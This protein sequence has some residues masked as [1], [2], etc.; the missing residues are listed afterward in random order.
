LST[1]GR[2]C[3]LLNI[4]S[5]N[6]TEQAIEQLLKMPPTILRSPPSVADYVSLSEYQAQTP[7]T[8]HGG[9]PVLYYHATSVI[10][11]VFKSQCSSL[12]FFSSPSPLSFPED[13][14][15]TETSDEKVEQ[16]VDLFINSEYGTW[17][18]SSR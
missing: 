7:E 11:R 18:P 14:A 17:P 8:F 16:L 2:I 4:I 3:L 6:N 15:S 1:T 5:N 12:P 9:K 10:A 13:G